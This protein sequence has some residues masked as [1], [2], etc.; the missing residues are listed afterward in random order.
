MLM[1][2]IRLAF[3]SAWNRRLTLSMVIM[4][5]AL[6]V[7]LLLGIERLEATAKNSFTQSV[8]GTDL[9][10]GARTS[11][12]QLMLYSIFH[13]GNATNNIRWE[14]FES[15][16]KHPS[17]AWAIPVSLGDSHLGFPV[18]ATTVGYFE[19]F[20]YGEKQTLTFRQGTP[21]S[22]VFDVVLGAEVAQQL[23]YRT[24]DNIVLTHG[25]AQKGPAHQDKPFMVTGIL[26]PTGTP[27]DRALLITLS[28]MEAI[29]L[30]WISGTT[31]PGASIPARYVNRFD[32]T[33]ETITAAFLGLKNRASVFKI[34][35]YI[36]QYHDEALLAVLPGVALADLWNMVGAAE[37]TL[38]AIS[39]MVVITSLAGL[40]STLLAGLNERRRELAILRAIG[41][42]PEHLFFLLL[43]EG[44][45]VSA[46][47]VAA[48][49][50]LLFAMTLCIAPWIQ[51][52]SGMNLPLYLLSAN[53]MFY[54]GI[55]ILTAAITSMLPGWKAYRLSLADGLSPRI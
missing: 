9:V 48:G 8:A 18:I 47:G 55:I 20:S 29:H 51:A 4:S 27:V 44:L 25:L 17:V 12:I 54:M 3:L 15:I 35:R 41:A 31:M 42:N 19:H 7:I 14:S 23:K 28:G 34:Q 39:A 37:K 46:S 2:L 26:A 49:I 22:G 53:E 1:T 40:V 50:V 43:F 6:S 10:I 16:K 21:F 52:W 11:P 13:L 38:K 33:P 24:G 5:I 32:L 36:N 30:D 45:F